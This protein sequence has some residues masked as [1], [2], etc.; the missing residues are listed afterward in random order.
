MT[1]DLADQPGP[2]RT[3]AIDERAVDDAQQ[4][5]GEHRQRHHQALLA[6]IEVQIVGD[7]HAERAEH[8]PHHEAH[9]EIKKGREERRP[10]ARLQ[11]CSVNH[12]AAPSYWSQC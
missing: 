10:V 9:V 11:E 4:R 7:L 6:G 1:I 3:D 5:A 12:D 8:D 2:L